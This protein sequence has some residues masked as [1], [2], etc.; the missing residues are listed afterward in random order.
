MESA[1]NF[2]TWLRSY[3]T[4]YRVWTGLLHTFMASGKTNPFNK[5]S[6]I[7]FICAGVIWMGMAIKP[8][9]LSVLVQL[10][11]PF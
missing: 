3:D 6:S 8:I 7:V 1:N 4:Q 10:I 5:V 11:K 9:Q 2:P